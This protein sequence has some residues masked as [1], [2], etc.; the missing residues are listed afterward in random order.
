MTEEVSNE[1][2]PQ[3]LGRQVAQ[4]AVLAAENTLKTLA[5][6]DDQNVD[7]WTGF[8]QEIATIDEE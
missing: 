8:Y 3:D 5:L 6:D 4:M 7:F 2:A 1:V